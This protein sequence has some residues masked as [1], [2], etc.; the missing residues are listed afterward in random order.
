MTVHSRRRQTRRRR[1]S[2]TLGIILL[3][4]A[5]VILIW[6]F[7][8]LAR[9]RRERPSAYAPVAAGQIPSSDELQRVTGN[10]NPDRIMVPYEGFTVAFNP[11][12]HIPDYVTWEITADKLRGDLPRGSF[13]TDPYVIGSADP[14]DYRNSGYD[15]GHLAPAA[16]MKW[17]RQAMSDCFM[18]PNIAPQA[19]R[20]NQHSWNNLEK[21]CRARAQ[22]DSLVIVV[23]G[24]VPDDKPTGVIGANRVAIPERYFKVILSPTANPPMAIGFIMQNDNTSQGLQKCALSVDRVEEITGYDFF[25]ALPDSIENQIES[26]ADFNAWNN[27]R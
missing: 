15:R 16:D 5:V 12:T 20:L 10:D 6:G 19:P 25:A 26:H 2:N 14:S 24:P 18:M 7:G 4:A 1:Q 9:D 23:A 8:T 11:V 13:K 3:A 21:R 22:A 17:S 27:P